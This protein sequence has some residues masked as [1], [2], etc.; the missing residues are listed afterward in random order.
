MGVERNMAKR[1]KRS[2]QCPIEQMNIGDVGR[3]AGALGMPTV[4]L[5]NASVGLSEDIL[6]RNTE[7]I[8]E[9]PQLRYTNISLTI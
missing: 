4:E 5:L 1:N 8:R 7:R 3:L 6:N 9:F 2:G